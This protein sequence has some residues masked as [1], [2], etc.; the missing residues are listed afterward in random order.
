MILHTLHYVGFKLYYKA[1]SHEGE[2]IGWTSLIHAALA[3][4]V[5]PFAGKK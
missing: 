2:S 5:L 4:A 3:L 1:K